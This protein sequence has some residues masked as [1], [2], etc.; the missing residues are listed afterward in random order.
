MGNIIRIF[1]LD[2]MKNYCI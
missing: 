1:F 2:E